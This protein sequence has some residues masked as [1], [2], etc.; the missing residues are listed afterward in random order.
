MPARMSQSQRERFLRGRHVAVL[1]TLGVDGAAVPTPIWYLFRN[2]CFYF[3]TASN[4]VKAKNARHDPRVSICV[5]DERPPYKAVVAHGRAQIDEQQQWLDRA[6]P[7]RY[8]GFIGAIGY[9]RTARS[10]VEQGSEVTLA[11]RPD[12]WTSFDFAAETPLVGR[13]WLLARCI[14]PPW[15]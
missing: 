2:G 10:A 14:L 4:A 12:R 15:L 11:V 3:R 13:L 7:R 9:E 6:I 1:V 8:L 5:Q